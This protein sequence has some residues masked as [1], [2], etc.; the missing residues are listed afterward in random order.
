MHWS[1]KEGEMLAEYMQDGSIG[2]RINIEVKIQNDQVA[3]R[4]LIPRTTP[5]EE[6]QIADE[7]TEFAL[8]TKA[9]G[10]IAEIP[11]AGWIAIAEDGNNGSYPPMKLVKSPSGILVTHLS[12]PWESVTPFTT[13]W[14]VIGLGSS[15]TQARSA[16]AA[17]PTKPPAPPP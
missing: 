6:L 4:Y 8:A 11:G 17:S 7:L 14:R 10:P 5:L 12:K 2:R 9:P 16:T 1:T 15:A 13:P 3:F